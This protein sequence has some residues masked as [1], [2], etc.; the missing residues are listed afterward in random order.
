MGWLDAIP[1][2]GDIWS[3]ADASHGAHKANRTAI[4]LAKENRDFQ[5]RM[6]NTAVQRRKADV[7]AAGF[8]PLLA[9]QGPGASTPMG[10][11]PDIQSESAQ[12][13]AILSST[14]DKMRNW[15]DSKAQRALTGESIKQ[16]A[17]NTKL[18]TA[19]TAKAIA[20]AQHTRA[21]TLVAMG[22]AKRTDQETVN[23]QQSLENMRADFQ[24][25][26]T[27]NRIAA[28]EE[29]VATGTKDQ[30]IGLARAELQR[31]LAELPSREAKAELVNKARTFVENWN[32]DDGNVVI[33]AVQDFLDELRARG[34]ALG[35]AMSTDIVSPV[36]KRIREF[37]K[38][39]RDGAAG[40]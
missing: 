15:L 13:S 14:A 25:I 12:S 33:L 5:E 34:D 37:H 38:H 7:V 9:V 6:S 18:I 40:R 20:E 26:L 39:F 24:G 29:A 36:Y 23:L 8:N 3:A 31:A 22:T 35:K 1:I 27:R 11:V 10:G 16:A 32:G 17:A 28:I 2:I 30:K 19:N 4:R 21:A